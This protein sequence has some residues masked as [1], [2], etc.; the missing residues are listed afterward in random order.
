MFKKKREEDKDIVVLTHVN[1]TYDL[2]AVEAIL[3]EHEIPYLLKEPGSGQY[4]RLYT[5]S[6]LTGTEI[7]VP[8][9]ALDQAR[10][11]LETIGLSDEPEQKD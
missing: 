1:T 8:A 5:G 4:M 10:E 11:L 7:L 9:A 2:G 6:S 3:K